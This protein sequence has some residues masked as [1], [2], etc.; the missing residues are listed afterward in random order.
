MLLF[1]GLPLDKIK[2]CMGDPAAD[3]ENDVLKAEQALQVGQG[4]RGDVTILPTLIINNAQYRGLFH[5]F[6]L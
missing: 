1:S 6:L 4:D 3:V 5:S 2:K